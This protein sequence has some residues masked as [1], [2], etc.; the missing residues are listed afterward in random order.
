[1]RFSGGKGLEGGNN[2]SFKYLPYQVSKIFS[3]F[4]MLTTKKH[5]R[6]IPFQKEGPEKWPLHPSNKG[7]RRAHYPSPTLGGTDEN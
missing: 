5:E 7:S 2:I 1:M 6:Q 4:T 3:V